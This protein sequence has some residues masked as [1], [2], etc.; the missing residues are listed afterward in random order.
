MV[1]IFVVRDSVFYDLYDADYTFDY[2]SYDRIEEYISNYRRGSVIV[3]KEV[4]QRSYS[5]DL[6]SW[7]HIE[8]LIK[9]GSVSEIRVIIKQVIGSSLA[10]EV[11]S[12]F[13]SQMLTRIQSYI[14]IFRT[15]TENF[16]QTIF[17]LK[18]EI[19]QLHE[20][21]EYLES[22]TVN[23]EHFRIQLEETQQRLIIVER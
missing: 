13:L 5:Y 20:E 4:V 21:L 2:D 15:E 8:E 6:P 18:E 3:K 1:L 14:A 7:I 9:A 23:V 11:K 22:E 17:I 12:Q 10:C 19:K 16:R